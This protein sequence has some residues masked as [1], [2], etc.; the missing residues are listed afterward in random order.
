[1]RCPCL[2]D[3]CLNFFSFR[4]PSHLCAE[5]HIVASQV[6]QPIFSS[7]EMQL[8]FVLS[9]L[10]HRK[11]ILWWTFSFFCLP[12]KSDR[13]CCSF[14]ASL[15][16]TWILQM[17]LVKINQ[18][19]TSYKDAWLFR[20][21]DTMTVWEGLIFLQKIQNHEMKHSFSGLCYGQSSGTEIMS[22]HL[23][24]TSAYLMCNTSSIYPYIDIS[25]SV[26]N[27]IYPLFTTFCSTMLV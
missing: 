14:V 23:P 6:E 19:N 15:C 11:Q 24:T 22:G 26:I 2:G 1:M 3:H 20:N 10:A 27:I 7:Q 16:R 25:D 21:W 12:V 18:S 9:G 13:H 17:V 4:A 5:L 8:G